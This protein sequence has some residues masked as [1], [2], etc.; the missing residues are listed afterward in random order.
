[1]RSARGG[2]PTRVDNRF[3]EIGEIEVRVIQ[4]DGTGIEGGKF[5]HLV[6]FP[7]FAICVPGRAVRHQPAVI[8]GTCEFLIVERHLEIS[9][10]RIHR[11]PEIGNTRRT[12]ARLCRF[13]RGPP[14]VTL[15]AFRDI[16]QVDEDCRLSP[17]GNGREEDRPAP[18][19][20]RFCPKTIMGHGRKCGW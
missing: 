8:A 6:N 7:P 20:T 5:E 19:H 17:L 3:D 11:G 14:T 13:F 4:V 15:F 2:I 10:C 12:R 18:D 1:M 9:H 16:Q